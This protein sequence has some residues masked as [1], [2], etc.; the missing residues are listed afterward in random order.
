[1]ARPMLLRRGA[2]GGL[3]C[4]FLVVVPA[5]GAGTLDQSQP[6]IGNAVA[7]VSNNVA[8][9]Q[10]FTSGLTGRLDQVD[11]AVSRVGAPTS[12]SLTVEIRTASG[13]V[14]G[15]T[16]LATAGLP[17]TAIPLAFSPPG[18]LSVPLSPSVPVTA[19]VQYAIVLSSGSCGLL[20][21]FHWGFPL[22]TNPY[23]GGVG[24]QSQSGGPWAAT[25]FL[26]NTDLAFKTYV[27]EA[28]ASKA[29]C[30]NGGWKH[31]VNP[32]FKNQGRCVAYVNHHHGRGKDDSKAP[33][34]KKDKGKKKP[35]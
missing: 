30:K 19:G 16:V 23:A 20:N 18:F 12:L 34:A 25:G 8:T 26:V 5:A 17:G 15:A 32:R 29:E 14:P 6:V 27:A 11:V 1:M 22:G 21:C 7:F 9:A 35:K 2:C 31:F 33:T 10:S 24:L 4:A 13:G 3:L 28:P